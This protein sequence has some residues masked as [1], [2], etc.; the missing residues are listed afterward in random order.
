MSLAQI[1]L[2]VWLIL[3]GINWI[4]WVLISAVFLG[5]WALV[6]GILLILEGVG[7]WSQPVIKR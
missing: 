3:V 6:T 1:A 4:G 2:A 7:A 5:V